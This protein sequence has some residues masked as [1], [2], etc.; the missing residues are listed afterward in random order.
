M[1]FNSGFKGLKS[2]WLSNAWVLC[3]PN[4]TLIE[5]AEQNEVGRDPGAVLGKT[6]L[7]DWSTSVQ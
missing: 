5:F 3:S 7:V 4:V 2:P 1:G 6:G